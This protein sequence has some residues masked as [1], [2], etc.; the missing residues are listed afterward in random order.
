MPE[1]SPIFC[2][3]HVKC[4]KNIFA[5]LV[6]EDLRNTQE[7]N[8]YLQKTSSNHANLLPADKYLKLLFIFKQSLFV[9]NFQYLLRISICN[10]LF[11]DIRETWNGQICL[12][13]VL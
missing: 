11:V 3:W 7:A 5:G 10:V 4:K 1:S 2:W 13:K 6:Y 12:K 9:H 8:Y